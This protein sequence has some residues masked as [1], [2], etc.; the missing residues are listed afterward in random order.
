MKKFKK[1]LALMLI[2]AMTMSVLAGC[3]KKAQDVTKEE[4]EVEVEKTESTGPKVRRITGGEVGTLNMHIVDKSTEADV[5]ALIYGNLLDLIYDKEIE[6]IKFVPWHAEELPAVSEDGKTWTFKLKDGIKWTDGTPIDAHNYE[7]SYKMLLDPKLVNSNARTFFDS[8]PVV[9]A[10]KYFLGETEWEDVGIKALDDKTLE[11]KLETE[12]PEIDVLIAFTGG[13]ETSPVHKELY[14]AGMN[15]DRTETNYATTLENIPFCGTYILKEWIKDQHRVF[16]KNTDDPM[17]NVYIADRIEERMVSENSTRMQLFEKGEIDNVSLLGDDYDRY[18]EDPRLVK[19][20]ARNVWGFYINGESKKN[21]VLQDNDLRKALF[22]GINR[23][24]I[25]KGVFKVYDPAPYFISTVCMV[26]D[27]TE[28]L[29]YRDTKE[30]KAVVP[31]GSGFEPEKAKEY[32]EKAYAANG[33]KKIEIELIYFDQDDTMTRIAEVAEEEYEK[34]FGSDKLDIKLRSM[35]WQAAYD[36]YEKGDYDMGIGSRGQSPF[37]AWKSLVVWT[38]D[39]PNKNDTLRNK[40][41]DELYNR[42]TTGDLIQKPQ[43]R[44]EALARMEEIMVD[45]VP[46]IPVFQNNNTVIFQDRIRL[47]TGGKYLPG[48]GF[49]TNQA[50]ILD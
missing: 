33:N 14:E 39:F 19:H 43:E 41:F 48:V 24:A 38:S 26:G 49:A 28:G 34:L 37:N 12:M 7:Y 30:A 45:Y 22:Y 46:F 29:S 16:E 23:D 9:N 31:E 27:Y 3:G 18:A 1:L 5:G 6:N 36:A 13:S 10:K 35:P 44:L 25:A 50:E 17:A 2:I 42:T 11:I 21:P 4:E 20:L 32:F 40:E 47:I 8:I 15:A